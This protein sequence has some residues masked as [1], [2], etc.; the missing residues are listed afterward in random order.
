MR[1]E[2]VD[3]KIMVKR[4]SFEQLDE[5][6]QSFFR[7][8]ENE[9]ETVVIETNAKLRFQITSAEGDDVFSIYDEIWGETGKKNISEEEAEQAIAEALRET[10]G[11][12]L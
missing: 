6:V 1:R 8:I 7:Q 2:N 5:S 4:L 3:K 11:R 10:T 9:S 12:Q